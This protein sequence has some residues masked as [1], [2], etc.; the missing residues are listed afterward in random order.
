MGAVVAV[1]GRQYDRATIVRA[2]GLIDEGQSCR[3]VGLD[4]GITGTTVAVWHKKRLA[5]P[6][7]SWMPQERPPVAGAKH[8][9]TSGYYTSRC[10]CRPCRDAASERQRDYDRARILGLGSSLVSAVGTTRRIRAL[11]ALGWSSDHIAEACGMSANAV[12]VTTRNSK[13]TRDKEQ[14]IRKA[15]DQLSMKVGPHRHL[16]SMARNLGYAPPL[17][18]DDDHIDDPSA[19]PDSPN[20]TE[21][22]ARLLPSDKALLVAEVNR[23]GILAVAEKYGS[24]KGAVNKALKRAG[25]RAV[26]HNG[27]KDEHPI[28][29]KDAA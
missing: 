6:S 24:T 29:R 23:R 19:R 3:E 12:R 10:R 11:Y 16:A 17:A 21:Q 22:Y 1:S 15:Y 8:G 27:G 20:T 18:W 13:V 5:D 28:Y 2:L 14:R 26:T 25:Y 4:M 7:L 9:T